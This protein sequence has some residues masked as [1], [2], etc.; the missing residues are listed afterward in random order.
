MQNNQKPLVDQK[1]VDHYFK[2]YNI[3]NLKSWE[4]E[5]LARIVEFYK[6]Y[7][8]VCIPLKKKFAE[9][10]MKQLEENRKKLPG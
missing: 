2:K 6:D 5:I 9:R 8:A 4:P 3:E 7:E 1:E 10:V